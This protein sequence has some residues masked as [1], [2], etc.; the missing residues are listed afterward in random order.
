MTHCSVIILTYESSDD[1]LDT[2]KTVTDQTVDFSYEVIVADNNSRDDTV[3]I[4]KEEY[5]SVRILEF[6]SNWGAAIG[7]NKALEEASGEYVSYLN[8]DTTVHQEW[9]ETL[10]T[11]LEEVDADA[12]MSSVFEPGDRHYE[13]SVRE[14]KLGVMKIKDVTTTGYIYNDERRNVH[15]PIRTLHLAGNS[16]LFRR[17]TLNELSHPF[18]QAFFLFADDIDMALRL[19]VLGK[20]TVQVP[21][22]V[23]Y[24]HQYDLED[25]DSLIWLAKKSIWAHSGRLSSFFKN[26]YLTEFLLALP[27]L[28]AG[29]VFNARE[30]GGSSVKKLGYA[31]GGIGLSLVSLLVFLMKIPE[32]LDHRNQVLSSRTRGRFWLLK[33]L[34][35]SN[36]PRLD[37]DVGE[38]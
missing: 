33:K 24:H 16:M 34:V 19:N 28:L 36:P 3:A 37:W 29:G 35:G 12:A 38:E 27:L 14:G 22:A 26:M 25:P 7:Y 21:D 17:D 11:G 1:I 30:L 4:V 13:I 18:E 6:K 15:Q 5:P 10:L 23:V 20:K 31:L 32:L 8:P 9:L 2:L